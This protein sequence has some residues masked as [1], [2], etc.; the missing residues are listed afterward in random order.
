MLGFQSAADPVALS[1]FL[2]DVDSDRTGTVT[3]DEFLSYF[4]SK[5]RAEME[6]DLNSYVVARSLVTATWYGPD[7]SGGNTIST[8][9]VQGKDLRAWMA[10]LPEGRG[11]LWLDVTGYDAECYAVLEEALGK[12]AHDLSDSVLIGDARVELS[13]G[14]NGA[15]AELSLHTREL[16]VAPIRPVP[17]AI[18]SYFPRAMKPLLTT[19]LGSDGQEDGILGDKDLV[20]REAITEQMP[21]ISL[22]QA[23]MIVVDEKT[24]I[25]L[26]LLAEGGE[27]DLSHL[28]SPPAASGPGGASASVAPE[29]ADA[30]RSAASVKARFA[31]TADPLAHD[32]SVIRRCYDRV[33]QDMAR[34]KPT[35]THLFTSS[36][37]ALAISLA[38]TILQ[39]NHLLRDALQ[40]WEHVLE[41]SIKRHPNS[42]H[43]PHLNALDIL[44]QL[45]TG[46]IQHLCS[47]LDPGTWAAA[48]AADAEDDAAEAEAES[49]RA[50]TT[51]TAK[52]AVASPS[53]GGA[54][55]A[56]AEGD[57]LAHVAAS[58]AARS[59]MAGSP[60]RR[61]SSD[62]L[63]VSTSAVSQRPG[64]LLRLS[65]ESAAGGESV[66]RSRL[67]YFAAFLSDFTELSKDLRSVLTTLENKRRK[68]EDLK[69]LLSGLK[70]DFMNKTLFVL[71]IVTAVSVPPQFLTG[72]FGMNFVDMWE[73]APKGGPDYQ[74]MVDAG[75]V[76]PLISFPYTGYRMF[77]TVLMV[78][79]SSLLLAMWRSGLFRALQ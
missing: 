22:E 3:E 17:P 23:T 54:S 45:Y 70:A 48:D 18:A 5:T 33:R 41:R 71:T 74:A 8:E 37:K 51:D 72:L 4:N 6:A 20:S 27:A 19:L 76:E 21:A 57:D 25:T 32:P 78:V 66:S 58:R 68:I 63:P 7:A 73:L 47:I 65:T 38:D 2:L 14:P 52:R 64:G 34:A 1:R 60:M 9:F 24:L 28:R 59:M 44:T 56:S 50:A 49:K 53:S 42:S 10:A 39:Q 40:D 62:P 11:R 79:V 29:S 16:S 43:L 13:R 36:A 46:R 30:P 31:S 61:V 15:R 35:A 67:A 12:P 55:S 26:R 75:Y 77:W 69:S